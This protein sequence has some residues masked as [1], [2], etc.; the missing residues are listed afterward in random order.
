MKL[1][2]SVEQAICL[3]IMIAH[4]DEKTPL[5]SYNI[6]KSLGVSD[7]YLKKIIRQLVVA[8]LITSEAGKKGG[9]S[10]KKSSDKITLLDIFEAI[11]GKEPFA[12]A[13][14]LVERVFLN[15]LKEVKEQKQ[16]MI[17]EAFNQAEKS[18]K[19]K[20]KKITLQMAMV[21]R[22]KKTY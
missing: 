14:G 8:G 6:S 5:K 13:T 3:L 7:S 19:E 21:D 11:E 22:N 4:S 10:L 18:Y 20:L 12:R 9:V 2:N 15:E 17:L 1:K 16:A